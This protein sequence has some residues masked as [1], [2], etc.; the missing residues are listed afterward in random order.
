MHQLMQPNDAITEALNLLPTKMAKHGQRVRLQLLTTQMQE[1][2]KQLRRQME[3]GP[4]RGLWQFEQNGGVRGVLTHPATNRAAAHLCAARGVVPSS[5]DAWGE[6]EH[7]DVLAAGFARLLLWADPAP[8]PEPGEVD[9]AFALYLNSWRPG[10]YHRGSES[11]KAALWTKWQLN[12]A[13]AS[14]LLA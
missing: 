4:A 13:K 2:P 7:D 8:L 3:N 12:Y 10:A 5:V 11:R 6:L 1:D 14:A 9:K